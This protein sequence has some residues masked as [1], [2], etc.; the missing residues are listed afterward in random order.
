MRRFLIIVG[1]MIA[2]SVLIT[3]VLLNR[4]VLTYASLGLSPSTASQASPSPIPVATAL[5]TGDKIVMSP[6]V[7]VPAITGTVTEDSVRAYLADAHHQAAATYGQNVKVLEVRFLLHSELHG[8]LG[9]D[10]L[11]D[12]PA[13]QKLVFVAL[14]GDFRDDSP[15]MHT[16]YVIFDVLTGNLLVSGAK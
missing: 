12:L 14:T 13:N 1:F 8:V 7:G 10:P 2:A 6:A 16:G 15:V 3:Q 4:G 5:D 9:T 11:G